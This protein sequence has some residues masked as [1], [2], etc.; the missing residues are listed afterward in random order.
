MQ[1]EFYNQPVV[2]WAKQN[3][4]QPVEIKRRFA[5]R[6]AMIF[7]YLML[8]SIPLLIIAGLIVRKI[9]EGDKLGWGGVFLCGGVMLLPNIVIVLLGVLTRQKLVKSLDASGVKTS[10]GRKFLWENLYYVDHVS[11]V[12]R[13]A[14]VTR[15]IEDNQLELVFADGKAIIP[16]LIYDRE[17][18][19]NLVN[20]MP[21]QVRD[22]GEI[23]PVQSAVNRSENAAGNQ[24]FD[25]IV[26]AMQE[27]KARNDK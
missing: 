14:N 9:Q 25:E 4:S 3:L 13:V 23:R 22:D 6:W 12:T 11:K 24:T 19:W 16:P 1:K 18:I 2:N 20:S 15:K 21:A 8:F 26:K 7:V 5:S 17:R 10:L 27:L